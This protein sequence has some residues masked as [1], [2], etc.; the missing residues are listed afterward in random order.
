MPDTGYYSLC[1]NVDAPHAL[2][3][4]SAEFIGLGFSVFATIVLVENFGSSFMKS[5]QV[6]YKE[7]VM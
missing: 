4:G 2:R 7:H 6:N 5:A 1:P 3:W